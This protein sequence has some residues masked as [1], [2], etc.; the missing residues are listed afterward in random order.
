[1]A[2]F[3]AGTSSLTLFT[4]VIGLRIPQL[5]FQHGINRIFSGHLTRSSLN[6]F[7]ARASRIYCDTKAKI[8]DRIVAGTCIIHADETVPT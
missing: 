3:G 8:L 5:T 6:E 7:K 4:N 2:G 1:M